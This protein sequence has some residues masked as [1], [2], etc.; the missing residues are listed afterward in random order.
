MKKLTKLQL[1]AGILKA[2]PDAGEGTV[3]FLIERYY[4]DPEGSIKNSHGLQWIQQ[5]IRPL[6]E[7]ENKASKE[8]EKSNS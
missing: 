4:D 1:R 3:E 8:R 5:Y 6:D 7:K 2:F